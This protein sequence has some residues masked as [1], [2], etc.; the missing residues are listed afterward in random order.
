ML[1]FLQC[2]LRLAVRVQAALPVLVQGQQALCGG[3]LFQAL[4]CVVGLVLGLQGLLLG[5]GGL[6]H[7][8]LGAGALLQPGVLALGGGPGR[9]RLGQRGVQLLVAGLQFRARF[10]GQQLH[11]VGLGLGACQGLARLAGALEHGLGQL[12]VDFGAGQLFQQFG[13]VVGVGVQEGGKAALGQQHGFGEAAEVQAGDLCDAPGLVLAVGGQDVARARGGIDLGQLDLGRLQRTVGLVACAAL[14]PEGAV[15]RGLHLELHLGQAVGRV[16]GHQF[17]AL[18]AH[19]VQARGLVVQR[20]ADGI[21]QGG[22][23]GARG[24]GDGKQAVVGKRGL[25]KVDLPFALE[26]VE[27]LQPQAQ[28]LHAAPPACSVASRLS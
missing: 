16:A 25:A 22:L 17:V 19:G 8:L 1:Q 11:A 7:R 20:Q 18:A 4:Q 28:D 5:R 13:A 10:G 12:A 23:A 26:G 3:I 27:V 24:A 15:D 9:L 6:L 14:A 21:Q 2:L